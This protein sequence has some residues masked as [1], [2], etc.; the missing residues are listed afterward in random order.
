MRKLR[1]WEKF[2]QKIT[3]PLS[4][5]GERL[6]R[7]WI[8]GSLV[9]GTAILSGVARALHSTRCGFEA[10]LERFSR[11]FRS[12][13]R[14]IAAAVKLYR[15]R[16]VRAIKRAGGKVV[17]IDLS[18]IV[19]PYGRKLEYLCDVRD[20]SKSSRKRTVIEKGWWTV[21]VAASLPDHRVLPLVRHAY[22]T[23]HPEFK[24]EQ[25]E[26]R[27]ALRQV[28]PLLPPDTRAVLDRGFDGNTFFSL[29]DDFFAHWAVRQRGDR[30]VG[31][32]GREGL[33]R[34]ST[35]AKAVRQD[36]VAR[37]WVVRHGELRRIEISFGYC[38]VELPG[39]KAWRRREGTREMTLVVADHRDDRDDDLPMM[40][41]VSEPVKNAADARQWVEDYYRRW[42]AEEETRA[43]KQLGGLEDLRVQRWDAIY[44][45]VALSIVTGGL[46][47]L[48]DLE[49]PRRARRLARLAPIDGEVPA[50]ARY[51]LWMSVS[52]LLQ[53][54]SLGR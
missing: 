46:L 28:A 3:A 45:L 50:F 17:A 36:H 20:A 24:S 40:L 9:A 16:A 51:R 48:L 2:V 26:I 7:D 31:L 38:T 34:M 10:A 11:G 19:K 25:D 15:A 13:R 30:D 14:A 42:G 33:C 6:V 49:N 47:A 1:W 22:S 39:G 12:Q 18:E 53:G 32:P 35:V 5:V 29:L 44:N 41:L 54:R 27:F 21:E 4:S 52:L 23:E 43:D 37:P 8:M